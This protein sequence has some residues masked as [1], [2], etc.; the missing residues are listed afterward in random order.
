MNV[1]KVW[2]TIPFLDHTICLETIASPVEPLMT[3]AIHE[4]KDKDS[5]LIFQNW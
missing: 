2:L 4:I 1:K 3:A 5:G